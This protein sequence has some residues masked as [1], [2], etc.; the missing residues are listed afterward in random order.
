MQ[1]VP[2]QILEARLVRRAAEEGAEPL[3]G[4]DV[5]VLGPLRE[6]A[7][8]HILDHASAQRADGCLG[9]GSLPEVGSN[10]QSSGTTPK[11][12][13]RPRCARS[14]LPRERFSPLAWWRRPE[15]DRKGPL[16]G[17]KRTRVS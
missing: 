1:L 13:Y 5:A 16:I 6:L 11:S 7:D 15:R 4:A 14:A 9:H 3:D 2:A 8:R 10:S 12:P 17:I